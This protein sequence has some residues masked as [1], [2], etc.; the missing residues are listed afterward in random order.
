MEKR[1]VFTSGRKENGIALILLAA[2]IVPA[3]ICFAGG[4]KAP[5]QKTPA[6]RP[7]DTQ[8]AAPINRFC[9][10]ETENPVDPDVPTVTYQGKV[11][12]F[13]CE[14]CIPTFKK[15]PAKYMKNLK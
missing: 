14:D 10:V 8:S 3:G 12:G 7:A 4:D 5:A 6:T 1:V 2:L 13:C 15:D 11:I 9:A